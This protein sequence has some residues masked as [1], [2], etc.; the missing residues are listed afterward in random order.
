MLHVKATFIARNDT[1][2]SV[3]EAGYTDTVQDCNDLRPRSAALRHECVQSPK[4]ATGLQIRMG[5]TT[6]TEKHDARET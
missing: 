4:G 3:V 5:T 2:T 6:R 1:D